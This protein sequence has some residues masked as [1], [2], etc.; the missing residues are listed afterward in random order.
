[1]QPICQNPQCDHKSVWHRIMLNSPVGN[2]I[3]C[4]FCARD[5]W[6][7]WKTQQDSAIQEW[8]SREYGRTQHELIVTMPFSEIRCEL[9]SFLKL[10][11]SLSQHTFETIL[12][13]RNSPSDVGKMWPRKVKRKQRSALPT[14]VKRMLYEPFEGLSTWI[15]VCVSYVSNSSGLHRQRRCKWKAAIRTPKS[16]CS[17]MQNKH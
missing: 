7:G 9:R 6:Q 11:H 5:N 2:W 14:K 13:D 16:L 3:K 17:Q 1:M 12:A 15:L 8:E 4:S 10:V